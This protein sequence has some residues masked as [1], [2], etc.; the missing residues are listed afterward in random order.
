[1]C[2][3]R[4]CMQCRH[5]VWDINDPGW[6]A[7]LSGIDIVK[8]KPDTEACCWFEDEDDSYEWDP[9]HPYNSI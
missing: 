1:M 3:I 4:R 7:C 6:I 8:V 2:D 9:E 5:G